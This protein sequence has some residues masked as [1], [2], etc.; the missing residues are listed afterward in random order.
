V[1]LSYLELL[2]TGNDLNKEKKYLQHKHNAW[3]G[4]S[5]D[6]IDGKNGSIAVS[7]N[8]PEYFQD[9]EYIANLY[10]LYFILNSV[11]IICN[12][13]MEERLPSFLHGFICPGI[14]QHQIRFAIL[15]FLY[16]VSYYYFTN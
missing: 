3:T 13:L 7:L 12:L 2:L 15:N 8:I 9:T 16:F 4:G 11:T 1:K 6:A 10:I 14:L 5:L